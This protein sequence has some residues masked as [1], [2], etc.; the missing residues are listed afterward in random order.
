[1]YINPIS[2]CACS[3]QVTFALSLSIDEM[4]L[5][6][7]STRLNNNQRLLINWRHI[8]DVKEMLSLELQ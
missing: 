8:P 6:K 1:M 7:D 5:P 4:R 3:V 2:S